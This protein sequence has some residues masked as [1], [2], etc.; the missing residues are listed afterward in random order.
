MNEDYIKFKKILEYF[1][2]IMRVNN[3][4]NEEERVGEEPISGQGYKDSK[5]R[6]SYL[7]YRMFSNGYTIDVSVSAG[8]NLFNKTCYIHWTDTGINIRAKWNEERND[9]E[10]F[11]LF[12]NEIG[13]G[14]F[15]GDM[16]TIEK[17]GLNDNLPP[18]SEISN[19]FNSFVA[20]LNN[21]LREKK[22]SIMR[23]KEISDKLAN[24]TN[25]CYNIILR[26][27]PGTGKTYLARQ[28]AT[29]VISNGEI[30]CFEDLSEEQK[31]QFEFVQFHPSY[32][33]TDFVEGL[34][35]VKID[36]QIGFEPKN[37]IFKE[38]CNKAKEADNDGVF[39]KSWTELIKHIKSA[40][41]IEVPKE[42]GDDNLKFSI[43][44]NGNLKDSTVPSRNHSLTKEN[45]FK[46]WKGEVARESKSHS[47]RMRA[48]VKF[49]ESNFSLPSYT[50]QK[51]FVFVIDEINRG[52]ISKIFGELFFSLDPEYRGELGEVSTQYSN[53]F[54]NKKFYIPKNVY[55][56][57]TMNDIDRSVDIFDFAMRRRFVFEE[58]TAQESQ[59]MLRN[60][61]TKQIMKNLN[62]CIVSEDI[63][64]TS[65]Y[66]IG[67]SYFKY[68]DNGLTNIE[69]LW[70]ERL[71]P[72][73]N[74]YFRGERGANQKI[75][76]LYSSIVGESE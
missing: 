44:S 36:N 59:I 70:K 74:D 42:N 12:N 39:E 48:V 22:E 5:I 19:F 52:E 67:G 17:L 49:M 35:P 7:D 63:G 34:R 55:V 23:V 27:A 20:M 30:N 29:N 47:S 25:P 26:G 6:N 72:L 40:K 10:G 62:A 71:H 3:K 8:F 33:Y 57:G 58:V 65:D 51:K 18:N 31:S 43:N 1:L 41:E 15:L 54:D 76:T 69:E 46:T 14:I 32:D 75:E 73:F 4:N 53:L 37:G 50:S 24:E 28:I 2:H 9:I 68:L 21:L 56:I 11:Q 13:N 45:I 66:Q 38:F 64:L 60:E 61:S 16:I